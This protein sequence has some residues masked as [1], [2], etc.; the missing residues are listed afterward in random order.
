MIHL[1]PV[2][3]YSDWGYLV[4]SQ[5]FE[6]TEHAK[7]LFEGGGGG[8]IASPT[9]DILRNTSPYKQT[10]GNVGACSITAFL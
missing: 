10:T 7:K 5:N 8:D 1:S 3:S 4:H 2:V 6:Y 9:A